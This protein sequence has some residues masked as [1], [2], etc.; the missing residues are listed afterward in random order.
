[1]LTSHFSQLFLV[2]GWLIV[3]SE[4]VRLPKFAFSV[5]A[6]GLLVGFFIRGNEQVNAWEAAPWGP[7]SRK[8]IEEMQTIDS[9][10]PDGHMRYCFDVENDQK[11][12]GASATWWSTGLGGGFEWLVDDSDTYKLLGEDSGCDAIVSLGPLGTILTSSNK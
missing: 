4:F 11:V 3:A 1:M 6:T 9:K 5:I 10:M 8:V 7:G 12:L 2:A